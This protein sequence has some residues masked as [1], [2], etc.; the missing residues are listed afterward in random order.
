MH[1]VILSAD[2][3][4]WV[5]ACRP[6]VHVVSGFANKFPEDIT[7]AACLSTLVYQQDEV[8]FHVVYEGRRDKWVFD[9]LTKR[10]A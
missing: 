9:L 8:K 6:E 10:K 7:C 3:E 4:Y 5:Y 2:Y 1:Y